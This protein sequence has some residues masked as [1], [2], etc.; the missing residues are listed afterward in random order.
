M[1]FS[2]LPAPS[3]ENGFL[4]FALGLVVGFQLS[5]VVGVAVGLVVVW[6]LSFL[7]VYGCCWETFY[8]FAI[9]L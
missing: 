5:L 4:A 8:I 9:V 1:L 3:G 6:L 7:V 2:W